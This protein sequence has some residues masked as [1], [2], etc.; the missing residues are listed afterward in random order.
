MVEQR[1]TPMPVN[2]MVMAAP[3]RGPNAPRPD[4]LMMT[5]K[6][7]LGMLRRHILLMVSMTILGFIIGGTGWYF[8]KKYYPKY[9]AQTYIGVLPP[10]E[11]DPAVIGGGWVGKDIQYGHR[12]SVA[13]LIKRQSN[14]Q[15]LID[16]D[17]VQETKWFKRFGKSKA[18]SIQ[19]AYKDLMK[20][21]VAFAHR[22]A[23]FVTISMTCSNKQEAA[24]IVNEMLDL[25]LYEQRDTKR[26]EVAAKLKTLK[27]QRVNVQRD[28]RLAID[29]LADIRKTSGFT[30]LERSLFEPT[31]TRKLN[32]L[33]LE[34]NQLVLDMQQIQT[35]IAT[36]GDLAVGPINEQVADQI[37]SDP[38]MV[39]LL[40]RL[41]LQKM[42]LAGA[43]TR[44]GENHRRIQQMQELINSTEKERE[45]RK[46]VIAEQ[47]R[48]A[49]LKDA[50]D[51]LVA[52]GGRFEQ[53]TR[54]REE[55]AEK[56]AQLDLAR[57]QYEQ[58]KT[59]REERQNMLNEFKKQ[60]EKRTIMHD[61]PETPKVQFVGR[62]PV[63]LR[64]SAP[65][66]YVY[67]PGGT[68]LGFMMG[69]VLAFL[70]E[71]LNDL[72][73]TPRD[74]SRFLHIPL[75]GLIPDADEDQQLEDVDLCHV[76]RQA[77]YSITSE[78]YRRFRTNLKLSDLAQ[79]AKVLLVTSGVA[80]EGKTSVAVNLATAFVAETK[81]VL[82]VDTNFWKPR[83]H[84]LFPGP[85]TSHDEQLEQPALGLNELLMGSCT[86]QQ[87]IKPTGIEGFDVIGSGKLP[88]NPA[89]L[90]GGPKM[91]L[92]IKN[93]RENYD[94]I[95]I[96]GP[97]VLLVSATK[98]L[99]RFVDGTILV[100][101][102]D[103]TRRGAAIR[104]IRE[105]KQVNATVVGCV[106]L[107]V[108]ALK[109]GYFHEQF[110]SLRDYRK[111][112]FAHSV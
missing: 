103:A 60:I 22:D 26:A 93:Q 85:E 96:D 17:K 100:F 31:I 112:Q 83:L 95:I 10:V 43:L 92:L 6:E 11:K 2:R 19:K 80:G 65:L 3:P 62:A 71:L 87:A 53:L 41:S 61:D 68:M 27:D 25:F 55:T 72:V 105:L 50:Q 36:L 20:H 35:S 108:K 21:F 110:R 48:Q 66:W 46:V 81:K 94:Y 90:L 54:M 78:S 56:K 1:Q 74:V 76:I 15:K 30:D 5:P 64:M 47:T 98:M 86:F 23:E 45:I 58:Q 102:A 77:P 29:M 16:K 9:T 73:R 51:A 63:P 39:M 111:L 104:S 69:I 109:G 79:S 106:L 89:E 18:I 14:L 57:V 99:A 88:S 4:A 107:A 12:L 91:E 34:Q 40:Q 49:N 97:P 33:E 28:L 59:I 24:L 37:E 52:L 67:F 70:I 84:T 101:N 75:L 7:I 38:T 44:F 82:L 8:L 32:D 13:N 42:E